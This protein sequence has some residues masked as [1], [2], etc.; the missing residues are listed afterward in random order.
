[1][2]INIT[3]VKFDGAIYP[4]GKPSTTIVEEYADALLAGNIFPPI[5]LESGTN[6][7]LDGYHRWKAHKRL[8]EQPELN[9]QGEQFS[10]IDAD[11]HIIPEGIPPKLYAA[12]LS[13][14]HGHRLTS[15][16]TKDLAREIC[17][18]NPDFAAQVIAEYV[19]RSERTVSD[20]VKDIK[21]RRKEQ[22]RAVIMRLDRLGCCLLY[23]SPSPRDRTRSRM[24]SSA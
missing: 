10:E 8:V 5:I 24:P 2:K 19:G 18:A 14:K 15:G 3:S 23:T 12:S 20:Y 21:G 17:E 16:E 4:R 22:Q 9:G 6:R 7:L 1:M 11:F 13:S